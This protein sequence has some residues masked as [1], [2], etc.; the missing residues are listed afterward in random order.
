MVMVYPLYFFPTQSVRLH[1]LKSMNKFYLL[2]T[3]CYILDKIFRYTEGVFFQ[4]I[5]SQI[6]FYV[7][8]F[9]TVD[10]LSLY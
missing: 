2:R 8:I 1:S 7:D 10:R 3:I 6:L 5:S 9:K 4:V